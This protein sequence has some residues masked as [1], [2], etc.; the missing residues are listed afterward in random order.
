LG[1]NYERLAEI[2][3]DLGERL[4]LRSR[5]QSVNTNANAGYGSGRLFEVVAALDRDAVARH[6]ISVQEAT[7]LLASSVS[8]SAGNGSVVLDGEAVDYQVKLVG[9]RAMDVGRLL[10]TVV[11]TPRGITIP[12]G[13]LF[14]VQERE[15]LS[16]I[17]REDQQ[18]ERTVAYEF[19]G[20]NLLGNLVRDEEVAATPPRS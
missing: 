12:L 5:V 14:T 4:A 6:G 2:A 8:N 10:E 3:D 7:S 17:L 20:P 13:D 15:V 16:T 9:Y 18:Y 11:T 1:Y 19:R